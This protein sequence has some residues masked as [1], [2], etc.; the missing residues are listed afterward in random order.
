MQ[1]RESLRRSLHHSARVRELFQ[2]SNG[3][4]QGDPLMSRAI[5]ELAL[6]LEALETTEEEL[7]QARERQLDGY[8]LL[9]TEV[10]TYRDLFM[11]APFVYLTTRLDGTIKRANDAAH[12]FLAGPAKLN[13]QSLPNLLPEDLRREF[14]QI[15]QRLG[16]AGN[17]ERFTMTQGAL[18]GTTVCNSAGRPHEIRWVGVPPSALPEHGNTPSGIVSEDIAYMH[19]RCFADALHV[20]HHT[21]DWA[22]AGLQL[23]HLLTT[24]WADLVIL[25]RGAPDRRERIIGVRGA[26]EREEICVL[27]QRTDA[28]TEALPPPGNVTIADDGLFQALGLFTEVCD[29]NEDRLPLQGYHAVARSNTCQWHMLCLRSATAGDFTLEQRAM[30]DILAQRM[31]REGMQDE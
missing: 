19:V 1:Q 15:L 10:Q 26:R 4:A 25:E 18:E 22:P 30:M 7:T 3:Q 28:G 6:L 9:E 29:W 2:R 31:S 14:R 27:R 16:S 8:A 12:T 20:F 11:S 24:T 5:D 21:S 13:G 17:T 23:A